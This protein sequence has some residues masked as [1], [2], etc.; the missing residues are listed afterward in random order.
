MAKK[1]SGGG[2]GKLVLGF[3]LG[4]AATAAVLFLSLRFGPLPVSVTDKP[5]PFEKQLVRLPLHARIDTEKKQAPFGTGEDVFEAGAHIYKE[6]C[7]SCHGTPGHDV[8]FA[9]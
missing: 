8:G 6:Q 1:S 5:F 7:A 2:F 4:I 9:R 3:L